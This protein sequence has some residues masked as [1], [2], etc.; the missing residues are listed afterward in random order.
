METAVCD[1]NEYMGVIGGML[2]V[3]VVQVDI[4][5]ENTDAITNAANETLKH[6]AG[7]AGAISLKGGSS[8]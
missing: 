5:D 7:V 4:T 2:T 8:I 3:Q 6:G 1:E